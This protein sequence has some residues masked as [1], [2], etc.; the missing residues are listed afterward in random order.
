MKDEKFKILS[1]LNCDTNL[2]CGIVTNDGKYLL[3][4]DDKMKDF[5]SMRYQLNKHNSDKERKNYLEYCGI[6]LNTILL[7][8]YYNKFL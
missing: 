2:I 7:Y 6:I 8:F 1:L 3:F 4:F 5:L